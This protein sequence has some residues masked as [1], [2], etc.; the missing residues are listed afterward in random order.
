[1]KRL[2]KRPS[3]VKPTSYRR[4]SRIVRRRRKMR[5]GFL[6]FLIPLIAAAI[7]AAPAIAGTVIASQKR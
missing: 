1:M 6:P 5:G 7:G 4:R 3:N 2:R